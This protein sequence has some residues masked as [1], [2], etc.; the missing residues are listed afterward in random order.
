M[1]N[2]DAPDLVRM[3]EEELIAWMGTDPTRWAAAFELAAGGVPEDDDVRRR[4]LIEWFS[5]A[6]EAGRHDR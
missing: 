1:G 3:S 4:W 5:T 6:I 2:G